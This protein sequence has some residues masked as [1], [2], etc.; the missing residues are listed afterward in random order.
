MPRLE[1]ERPVREIFIDYM[2]AADL[3]GVQPGVLLRWLREGEFPVERL[4]VR[5]HVR[6]RDIANELGAKPS[7]L[8][9]DTNR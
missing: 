5:W 6:L 9:A 3:L 1:P 4:R 8:K 7:E 2:M